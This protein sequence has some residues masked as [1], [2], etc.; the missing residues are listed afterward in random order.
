EL[1]TALRA[2][3]SLPGIFSPVRDGERVYVD[4]GLVGNLPTDVV[5]E[6]GADIVIGVHLETAPTNADA[7]RSLFQ[8]LGRSIY[9]VI[10]DN[11]IRGLAGADLVVKVELQDFSSMAYTRYPDIIDKGKEAAQQK[12]T[13]LSPY[14]LSDADWREYLQE[15]AG[16]TVANVAVPQFVKVE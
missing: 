10:R 4:G 2:T 1:S 14:A 3:M 5:R 8:V 13:V 11:E 16:R 7:I 6:M 12:S 9:V 15:R